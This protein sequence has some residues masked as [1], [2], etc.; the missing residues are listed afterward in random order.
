MLLRYAMRANSSLRT[1]SSG[2][3]W[4]HISI[5]TL[6]RPNTE[7]SC[8]TRRSAIA[9]PCECNARAATPL[10]PPVSTHQSPTENSASC[11]MPNTGCSL[12]P[13]SCPA[14]IALDKCA[15]PRGLR[16][17][18]TMSPTA[19][20]TLHCNSAPN[21][22]GNPSAR[23]VCAKRT[24]PYNPLRSVSASDCNSSATA[25]STNCSGC[26]APCKNEKFERQC[27]SEYGTFPI[28]S[29]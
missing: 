16:A 4:S 11:S 29:G 21:T 17:I 9:G 25:C 18:T 10:R 7:I 27:N 26:D 3:P 13:A 23:A 6:C 12:L 14:L 5:T 8:C 28:P 1:E 2:S 24:M 20:P 22:V 19:S 15:Y